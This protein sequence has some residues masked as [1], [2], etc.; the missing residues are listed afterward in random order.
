MG[1]LLF[2]RLSL[3]Y[4]RRNPTRANATGGSERRAMKG[5]RKKKSKNIKKEKRKFAMTSIPKGGLSVP[6]MRGGRKLT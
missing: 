2:E 4:K 5:F 1:V 6:L 3:K